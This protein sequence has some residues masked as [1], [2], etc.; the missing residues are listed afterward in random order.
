MS[1]IC[2]PPELLQLGLPFD[3]NQAQELGF[4]TRVVPD[5]RSLGTATDTAQ[6]LAEKPATAL[7]ACKRLMKKPWREQLLEAAKAE[8]SEFSVRVRSEDSKEGI[9]AFFEKRPPD[10][11]RTAKV[12]VAQRT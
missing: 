2:A 1:C 11:S 5:Q 8:N 3:A 7:Q 12:A 4:V 6:K 9:T 10:F